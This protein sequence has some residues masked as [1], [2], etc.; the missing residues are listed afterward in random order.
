MSTPTSVKTKHLEATIASAPPRINSR[1]AIRRVAHEPLVH[2]LLLGALIL[3]ASTIVGRH[4]NDAERRIVID[5]NLVMHFVTI[6]EAD[7]TIT[8]EPAP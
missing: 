7:G 8:Y 2:F 3:I 4:R 1:A 5:K 6:Y